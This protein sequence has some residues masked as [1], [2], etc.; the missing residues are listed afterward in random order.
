M[1]RIERLLAMEEEIARGRYPSVEKLCDMFE[2]AQRTVYDDIRHL[3]ERRGLE[4]EFDHFKKGYYNKN[5]NKKLPQFE[6]TSGEVFAL[7]LGK[8]MLSQYSGT[9]FEPVLRSGLEKIYERLSERVKFDIDDL[10]CM[11]RFSSSS[12]IQISRKM[13]LEL[14]KASE[15]CIS[16]DIRYYSA[17][18]GDITDRRINPCRL[19]ENRG[20]WYVVGFCHLRQALR[21]FALHRI[22]YHEMTE[23]IFNPEDYKVD[24]YLDSAFI[25]EHSEAEHR[26]TI[27]FGSHAARYI[28]ERTWHASQTLNEHE[29]GSCTLS[30]ITPSLDEAKRWVLG[31][32]AQA[33]VLE[34]ESFRDVIASELE[35]MLSL[36][37]VKLPN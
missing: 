28:R 15:Q 8:E 11:I 36:Y 2:V 20:T 35:K 23:E 33:E 29:D 25:L 18:R 30:F 24:D 26:V 1:S 16:V 17:H 13:M 10:K 22:Q 19:L 32:G 9:S 21:L 5:P 14:Y 12:T 31:Y 37:T 34:P 6:L 4:I 27:K 7:S 3:K